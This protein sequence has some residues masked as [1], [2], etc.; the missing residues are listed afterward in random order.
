[1]LKKNINI[2]LKNIGITTN[3]GETLEDK[4]YRVTNNNEP[5]DEGSP[6]IYTER[7]GLIIEQGTR[8]RRRRNRR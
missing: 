3:C 7:R 4:L 2:P 6:I 5:I 1:M 8:I